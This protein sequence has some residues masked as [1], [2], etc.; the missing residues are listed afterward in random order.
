MR[1]S[2]YHDVARSS[3]PRGALDPA[4]VPAE[5][6]GRRDG[7]AGVSASPAARATQRPRLVAHH[8]EHD[9][10][11]RRAAVG[12]RDDRLLVVAKQHLEDVD[13]RVDR[14]DR[15]AVLGA[16]QADGAVTRAGRDQLVVVRHGAAPDLRARNNYYYFFDWLHSQLNFIE[17]SQ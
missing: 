10:L 6:A 3:G 4:H 2:L 8:L 14:G 5:R 7:V 12:Q 11:A 17:Y 16:P 15:D 1:L 9:E 13:A